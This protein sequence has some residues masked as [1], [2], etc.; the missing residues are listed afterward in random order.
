MKTWRIL[1]ENGWE[2]HYKGSRRGAVR[3]AD[4]C[5]Y[6]LGYSYTVEEQKKEEEEEVKE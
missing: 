4:L 1:F 2:I 5:N 6:G 3:Y